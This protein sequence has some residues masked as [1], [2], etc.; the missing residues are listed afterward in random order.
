MGVSLPEIVR[1]GIHMGVEVNER[2]HAAPFR[3]R[4]QQRQRD[5][6]VAAER[7]QMLDRARLFLD[8]L[9]AAEEIA[10]RDLE[11]ADVGERESGRIDP[12]LRMRAVGQHPACLP[13]R[14]GSKARAAAVGGAEVERYAGDADRRGAIGARDAEKGRRNRIG[15]GDR[16]DAPAPGSWNR[17]TAAATTQVQSPPRTPSVAA[18]IDRLSTMRSLIS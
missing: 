10:E 2:E 11:V 18:V 9:E 13:D 7:D 4:A 16:H 14:R 12:V 6:V 1:P 17:N 15:G 5:P 8:P 3:Q